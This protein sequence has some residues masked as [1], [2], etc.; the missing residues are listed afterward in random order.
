MK[1][2]TFLF[3]FIAFAA[4]GQNIS[5][6]SLLER[7]EENKNS[8]ALISHFF[9]ESELET[10]T[11]HFQQKPSVVNQQRSGL[12]CTA[13]G[14][15]SQGNGYGSFD[16]TDPNVFTTI[17]GGSGTVDFEAAGA[18]N[19]TNLNQ[20]F[21]MDN[22][23]VLYELE[24]DSGTYTVLATNLPIDATGMAFNPVDNILYMTTITDLYTIDITSLSATLLGPLNNTG[25]LA[26]ALAID[27][28]G[29]AYTYDIGDDTFYSVDLTTG[30]ATAIGTIGFDAGFGQGMSWDGVNDQIVMAAFNATT[31]TSEVRIV[32]VTTGLSTFVDEI[33]P[34]PITQVTWATIPAMLALNDD[35]ETAQVLNV[36]EIFEDNPVL[37]DNTE[38]T[39]TAI[40][41]PSC[42]NFAEADLWY[43]FVVPESGS[44]SVEA[45]EDDGSITDTGIS[46][47]EG[48]IGSLVE[49]VCNDD[50]G[51]GFFSLAEVEDRTPGEVL[52]ARVWE[53]GGGSLGTFSMSA[54]DTPPPANDDPEGAIALQVGSV[55]ADFAITA[56]N[57]SATDTMIEDPSCANYGGSDVW[58]SV[59][60]PSTGQV[61]VEVD[62]AGGITDT[63]MSIYTGEI[64]ALVELECNDD[65]GNGLFSLISLTDQDPAA[66]LFIRVWEF[67]GN[68]FG[69][70]EIAAYSDCAVDAAAI[71][72]TGGGTEV[73]ICVG[74]GMPDPV[75]VTIVGEGIGTNNGW[76][77]TDNATGEILGLPAAPPFD[78][79]EIEP[80]VC[81]VWY[82]RFED[83]LVGLELGGN[84]A[85]LEGCFDFSNPVLID[86]VG[87]GGVCE[88]CEYTLEMN[89]SF[90]DGWNGA[91]MDVLVDGVVVLDDVA[92][93]DDPNNDGSQ[94]FLTFPV[95]STADVTT[96]FV[97]GGLFP[98]EVSYRIL[99]LEG[100]EVGTGNVNINIEAGTIL[101]DCPSCFAPSNLLADNITD[102]SADLSWT[103][104]NDPVAP[105]FTL[106]WGL[107]GFELGTGTMETGITTTSFTLTGLEAGIEYE[108]Y[109]TANCAV[110]D[111]S[112]PAGPVAFL[113]P[114]PPGDC[115]YT[116]EMNDSFG[117]GWN[118]A[119]M[120]V[121]RNGVLVLNDV[122]LDDD[123]NNDGSTG[124]LQF[125]VLPGDDITTVFVDGGDFPV[126]VSYRILDANFAVVATGDV[127]NDI[128]TGTV[129][130]NCPTCFAP[131]D[132]AVDNF[133]P[134]SVDLSWS[135][136][137]AAVAYNWEIQDIGVAQ[138]DPGAIA[139]GDSV[140]DI[141]DTALGAFIDGNMYTFFI[142]SDCSEDGF[143]DFVSLDFLYILPLANDDCEGAIALECGTTVTGDTTVAS[144]SGINAAPDVFY[145]Y[146]GEGLEE[147]ITLSLCDGATDYDSFLRVFD[148]ECNLVNQI[149]GNDDFCGLQSEVVFTSDGTTTYTVMV[150]GFGGNSGNFSMAI[151]CEEVLSVEDSLIEGFT[152]FP[153][154]TESVLNINATRELQTVT[155][156]NL[157]GQK[158]AEQNVNAVSSSIDV[159]RLSTGAYIL[160]V[161]SNNQTGVYKLIKK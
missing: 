129:T 76:V 146:T 157:S 134:G 89:D 60:P 36:G 62:T 135:M 151:T 7:L 142:Q 133:L 12:F 30:N 88:M 155:I 61:I 37:A 44:V 9:S 63:G 87:E 17:S 48:E 97:D 140:T 153:N 16:I 22:A 57:V 108:F 43:R 79:E 148:D 67:G 107:A 131:F 110:D 80:G 6:D 156:F 141:F 72:I 66:P 126:E 100:I 81:A 90:G 124:S 54:Y 96:I 52:F 116:L 33:L 122:A 68:G 46:I 95:N 82:I 18:V 71:E 19:Y 136:P 41:D 85:D 53:F 147:I 77:I 47:Y 128:T 104:N 145:T 112:A 69:P 35:P 73:S 91:V 130:A 123:P 106:E 10:L 26:I 144:D 70:F 158:V 55:F 111:S 150:E 114:P 20:A 127:D 105:D 39:A 160:Q 99:N 139:T 74:D 149:A 93:D 120:D 56:S 84:I 14:F 32:D 5:I 28:E 102:V 51:M 75:D 50:G 115:S 40:D 113:T 92:L 137:M 11:R 15:E 8:P 1:K 42:G 2:I 159:S 161:T 45:R 83:D 4:M 49:V 78:L 29:N 154:P 21:V 65:G 13:F 58:F 138:G 64:G 101:A 117:D 103:D 143:S 121:F 34:G 109:V 38:A 152:F 3:C 24:I 23:G 86:R 27:G 132:L 118:G 98:V 119:I 94:G 31:N 25:A 125:E 59:V